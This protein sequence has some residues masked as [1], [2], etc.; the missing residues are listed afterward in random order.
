MTIRIQL[1]VDLRERG[2][3]HEDL[4]RPLTR[5]PSRAIPDTGYRISASEYR[6]RRTPASRYKLDSTA[7]IGQVRDYRGLEEITEA[8][9][10][11]LLVGDVVLAIDARLAGRE[12]G[13][14]EKGVLA[15]GAQLLRA[16]AS[17]DAAGPGPATT[18]SLA[19]TGAALDAVAAIGADRPPDEIRDH[20]LHLATALDAAA[21][22]DGAVERASLEKVVELFSLVGDLE[23]AHVNSVS[24]E[25]QDPGRWLGRPTPSS[26]S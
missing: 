22:D 18:A 1:N 12:I 3:G 19:A 23:L 24:R 8:V 4:F 20:L 14:E 17:P 2:F 16:L 26:L 10:T 9:S 11:G 7:R 21:T 13:D 15:A 25:R 6:Q 5:L